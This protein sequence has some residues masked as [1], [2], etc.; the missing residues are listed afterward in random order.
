MVLEIYNF[1]IV[2]SQQVYLYVILLNVETP[3]L[4]HLG[5]KVDDPYS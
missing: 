2:F 5:V 4:R 3:P 1:H